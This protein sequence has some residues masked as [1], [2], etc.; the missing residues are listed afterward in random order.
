MNTNTLQPPPKPVNYFSDLE[1]WV[2]A[3]KLASAIIAGVGIIVLV[4]IVSAV[5]AH[6]ASQSG[7]HNMSTLQA[8]VTKQENK[9]A[10]Y[11]V[12]TQDICVSTGANTA[13]CSVQASDGSSTSILV[14]IAPDGNSWVSAP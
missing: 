3:H 10:G 11:A 1:I 13:T 8:S 4:I 2:K 6:Q 14:D 12:V 9:L 7:F 5:G